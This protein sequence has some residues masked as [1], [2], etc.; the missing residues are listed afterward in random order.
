MGNLNVSSLIISN[1]NLIVTV[2]L[3]IV[4]VYKGITSKNKQATYLSIY[5]LVSDA[6]KLVDVV[7]KDKFTYVLDKAYTKA[8]FLSKIGITEADVKSYIE[9]TVAKFNNFLQTNPTSTVVTE[10]SINTVAIVPEITSIVVPTST[11]IV[12]EAV[13]TPDVAV[14]NNLPAGY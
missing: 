12:P 1:Y 2:I 11:V 7:G 3:G 6:E 5:G 14:V 10:K 9:Y 8:T 13:I 4:A